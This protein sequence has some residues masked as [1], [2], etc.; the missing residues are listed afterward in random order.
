MM[1]RE[2]DGSSR[3][4]RTFDS[5]DPIPNKPY[6]GRQ[7]LIGR[8]RDGR[9]SLAYLVT[10]RDS[11]N[12]RRMAIPV[13]NGIRIVSV[14]DEPYDPL[15]H[16]TAVKIDNKIGLA[17]ATNGIQTE[18]IYETYRLLSY[19]KSISEKKYMRILLDGA[20]AEPD[21]YHTPRIAGLIIKNNVQSFS[22]FIG[23]KCEQSPAEIREIN[24]LQGQLKGISTYKGNLDIPRLS[25]INDEP[26]LLDF[27]RKTAEDLAEYLFDKSYTKYKGEDIRVCSIGGIYFDEENNWD[28]AIRNRHE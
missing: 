24:T 16:Y 21:T 25:S 17:V 6:L 11:E 23:I 8:T 15:R 27:N 1:Y 4:R 2:N 5:S 7:L 14:E 3:K 10:A 22:Y 28:L 26:L 19:V 18:A 13:E 9:P 12:R 20:G